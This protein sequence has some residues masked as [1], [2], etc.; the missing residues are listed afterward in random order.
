MAT[1]VP[2][3]FRR[4]VCLMKGLNPLVNPFITHLFGRTGEVLEDYWD[5]TQEAEITVDHEEYRKQRGASRFP[6]VLDLGGEG[7]GIVEKQNR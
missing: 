1:V 5:R 3:V 2:L 6:E 7:K 4:S